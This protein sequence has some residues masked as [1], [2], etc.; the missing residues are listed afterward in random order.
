[1]NAFCL[2]WTSE[3]TNCHGPWHKSHDE[4]KL[5]RFGQFDI[6]HQNI[7]E[8]ATP[9]SP[10][11]Q[12]KPTVVPMKRGTPSP[13]SHVYKLELPRKKDMERFIEEQIAEARR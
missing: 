5:R 1:M 10:R 6:A 7:W 4:M 12:P 9:E 3:A 13:K 8:A 11:I 2:A